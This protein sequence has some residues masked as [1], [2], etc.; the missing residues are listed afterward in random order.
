M[1][2]VGESYADGGVYRMTVD[3]DPVGL[4]HPDNDIVTATLT[5]DGVAVE[6]VAL[7][8]TSSD[9]DVATVTGDGNTNASGQVA[10]TVTSVAAGVATVT[11]LASSLKVGK[12]VGVV[13]S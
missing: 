5:L 4:T 10:F 13:V 8:G 7:T 2:D 9:T 3:V 12:N 6:G 11:F 1:A